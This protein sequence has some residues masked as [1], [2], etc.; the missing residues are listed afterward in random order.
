MDAPQKWRKT[1]KS[2]SFRRKVHVYQNK[3]FSETPHT[4]E[5]VQDNELEPEPG[6]SAL[7]APDQPRTSL[8]DNELYDDS[9]ASHDNSLGDYSPD[10]DSD[11]EWNH[12][13]D[14]SLLEANEDESN[15]K[16]DN[17]ENLASFLRD[18]SMQFNI[19]QQALK[20]LLQKLNTY[21]RTLPESPRRLLRTP[22]MI[23]DII[24]I[25]GGQYWHQGLGKFYCFKIRIALIT[26]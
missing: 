16:S 13:H 15:E 4:T 10:E 21:D 25:E 20:P 6:S 3:S 1:L 11:A 24:D 26:S 18:W 22:R 5:T 14:T 19:S 12:L 23:P 9:S 7:A 17:E 2:G 8:D